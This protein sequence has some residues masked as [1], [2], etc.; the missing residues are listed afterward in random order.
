MR[1]ILIVDDE[2][3]FLQLVVESLRT[4]YTDFNVLTAENGKKAV[5]VLKATPVDLVVTDLRMPEMDGFELLAYMR[6]NFPSIPAIMTSAFG[7]PEI[8]EKLQ[9]FG[10]LRFMSKPLNLEELSQAIIEDLKSDDTRGSLTGISLVSFLQ[11]IEIEQKTC[12]LEIDQGSK[13]KGLFYF[14]EGILYDAICGDFKGEKAA[15][16]VV[17]WDNVGISFKSLPKKKIRKR[18]NVELM[19]LIMEG[20]RLK[21][22]S[23]KAEEGDLYEM[24]DMEALVNDDISEEEIDSD[25]KVGL[26]S[27][28]VQENPEAL[29]GN[30]SSEKL[31]TIEEGGEKEK[32]VEDIGRQEDSEN[33]V[34]TKTKT[35]NSEGETKMAGLNDILKEMA[36]QIDGFIATGVVGMD[37]IS[38]A[39]HNPAGADVDALSAKFAMVM[40]LVE[41]SVGD[42]NLGEFEENLVQSDKAWILTRQL[43]KH[44]YLGIVV[45]RESTLGNVRLVS[46]K[47]VDPIKKSLG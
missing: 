45:S 17:S 34:E 42:L 10:T 41:K 35:I 6:T 39:Q 7:T 20:M 13:D 22:E 25:E 11:M 1:N 33:P 28:S 4:S 32:P 46:N 5:K 44:Y 27:T 47:Y 21:D 40:K 19:S 15:L 24:D 12:L 43:T 23:A 29:E 31:E 38:I 26:D 37:G 8:E 36:D 30:D 16:E 14:M 9:A 3:T 2:P 18:I